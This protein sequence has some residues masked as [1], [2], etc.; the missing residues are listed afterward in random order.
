M[1][2]VPNATCDVF[3]SYAHANNEPLLPAER[4]WVSMLAENV[5]TTLAM[6]IGPGAPDVWMDYQLSGNEPL[7]EQLL[8]KVRGAATLLVVFSRRY[9]ASAWCRDER[10]AFLQMLREQA[11]AGSRVFLV[12][13]DD[14]AV[15]DRPREFQEF[16]GYRFWKKGFEDR[17]E[18]TLGFPVPSQTERDYF[19]RITDLARDIAAALR[20]TPAN[21]G[22]G[23]HAPAPPGEGPAVFLAEVTE[24]LDDARDEVRRYLIQQGLRVLPE[25]FPPRETG[26]AYRQAIA[27][28]LQGSA[29]FV[30]LLSNLPG[31]RLPDGSASYVRL[32][33]EAAR[34]A[35][36]PVLQWRRRDLDAQATPDPAHRQLLEGPGVLAVGI[37]QLKT[38]IVERARPAPKPAAPVPV[39]TFVFVNSDLADRELAAEIEEEAR[40]HGIGIGV[41]PEG[42]DPAEYR[43]YLEVNLLHC[44]A[45]IYVYGRTPQSWVL[46]QLLQSRKVIA[47]REQPLR[48]HALFVGP[49]PKGTGPSF[50]IPGLE[51]LDGTRSGLDAVSD[52]LRRLRASGDEPQAGA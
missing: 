40:R 46:G 3:I 15:E 9:L 6:E 52:F 44:D 33:H 17:S 38:T 23:H 31:R 51:H 36:K 39:E 48:A 30:Q 18:R 20:V 47:R 32:Q 50:S 35:G 27:A 2:Y 8:E 19:D 37:E 29:V 21:G 43:A 14:V 28:D 1:P 13:F 26:E 24:D 7:G 41:P 12:E 4:G 25:R 16:L 42:A 11:Q 22:P 5:R 10:G 45:L 49:P 34:E